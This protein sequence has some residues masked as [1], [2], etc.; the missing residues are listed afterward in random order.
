MLLLLLSACGED[1]EQMLRQLTELERMNRADSVMQ[2]DTLAEQLVRYFDRHGDANERMRAHYILGRT[3]ADMG[4]APAA[5]NAYLDAAD[6]ADTT[7]IDCDYHT[8]SRVYGQ[9]AGVFYRQ[10]LKDRFLES[11]DLSIRCAW[12]DND[13]IQ[14]LNGFAHKLIGYDYFHNYDKVIPLFDGLYS[15]LLS[16]YGIGVAA[17]YC[18]V[19]FMSLLKLGYIE[20]AKQYLDIYEQESGYFDEKHN[21]ERGRE[22]YYYQRGLCY[23]YLQQMDSAEH[24]FRKE[25]MYGLDYTNQSMASHGLSLVFQQLHQ[26]DSAAKYAIY[27]YEMNDSAYA[28]AA[29]REV[30]IVSAQ[31]NYTR[32]QRIAFKEH[33]LAEQREQEVHRLYYLLTFVG[34]IIAYLVYFWHQRK[35]AAEIALYNKIEELERS[36][37][38]LFRIKKE[39][40]SCHREMSK[41]NSV[42]SQQKDDVA[43]L[44][45]MCSELEEAIAENE[46]TLE[47][48]GT[49]IV[50]L[51]Q[52]E[53]EF[54]NIIC[55]KEKETEQMIEELDH[56]RRHAGELAMEIEEMESQIDNLN[57]EIESYQQKQDQSNDDAE[58]RLSESTEY[59]HYAEV[60]KACNELCAKDFAAIDEI[61]KNNLPSFHKYILSRKHCLNTNQYRLCLLFRLHVEVYQAAYLL[62]VSPSYISKISKEILFRLFNEKGNGLLLKKKLTAYNE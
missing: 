1:H 53:Q 46:K 20:K 41:M 29:T 31:H 16:H 13:S 24:Y 58:I 47:L 50:L 36:H 23:L 30:E 21:V 59:R 51:R 60:F 15:D 17:K 35:K 22:V 28:Q 3:Y 33:V 42:I 39:E 61:V 54:L 7:A 62:G 43:K 56:H 12:I 32:H 14:A 5:L 34:I 11:L 49:E 57:K 25:L 48:K 8:L 9:M 4:E 37:A 10:N 45:K 44:Q 38:E 2:N 6:C 27:S 55:D 26:T 52:N 40:L 19:P 18:T